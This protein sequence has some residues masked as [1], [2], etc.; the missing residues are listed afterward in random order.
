MSSFF[1]VGAVCLYLITPSLKQ[2]NLGSNALWKP[3]PEKIENKLI[4]G[5]DFFLINFLIGLKLVFK[6][7]FSKITVLFN[8][9]QLLL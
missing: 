2:G 7:D 5:S 9:L 6:L 8:K 1:P 3:Q 4:Q